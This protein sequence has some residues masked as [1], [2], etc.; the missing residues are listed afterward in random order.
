MTHRIA[1]VVAE[2][3]S[4]ITSALKQGALDYLS[5]KNVHVKDDDVFFVPGAVELPLAAKRCAQSNRYDAVIVFGAVVKGETDH[6]DYVSQSVTYG[7]QKV[8]IEEDIPVI[9]G[10][11]TTPT[12]IQALD[13]VNGV[14]GHHG[15]DAGETVIKTLETLNKIEMD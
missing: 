8:A 2:F 13:R 15:R 14:R 4:D 7:C 12:R 3:N 9:F 11:L 5:E 6:Y 1:I 10:V